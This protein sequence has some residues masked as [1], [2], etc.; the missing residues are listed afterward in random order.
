MLEINSD[1]RDCL[2]IILAFEDND[3]TG[4]EKQLILFDLFYKEKPKNLSLAIQKALK[5]LNGGE[6][7]N[8]DSGSER[9]FSFSKDAG[10]I[11][12]AFKQTHGVDLEEIEYLHWWKF[13]ALFMDLGSETTFCTLVGLRKRIKSGKATKEDRQAARELGDVFEVPEIDT[14]TPDE[15]DQEEEFLR[16]IGKGSCND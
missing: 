12:A 9:Y 16:L 10:Y 4:F 8:E 7:G 15:R 11:F 6:D 2:K 13:L 3:L 14:R 5:F 1:F